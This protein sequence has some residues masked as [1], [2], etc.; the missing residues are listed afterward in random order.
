MIA[1]DKLFIIADNIDDS[2]QVQISSYEINVFRTFTEFESYI[3]LT[4]VVLD[5]LVISEHTIPFTGQNMARILMAVNSPFLKLNGNVVYLIGE[6]TDYDTVNIFLETRNIDNWAVYQGDLSVK[7]ITDIIVGN[8]RRAHENVNEI[9][10]YRIRTADYIKQQ[11]QL[12]YEDN[13]GKYKTDEDLLQGIPD[14]DEPEEITLSSEHRM[15]T[16]YIVGDS[17]M[18][19]SLMVFLLA[20]YLSMKQRVLI[21]EK[22]IDYHMLGEIVT[23]SDIPFTFIEIEDLFKN[24]TDTIDKIKL[25]NEKLVFVGTKNRLKYDYNFVFD[26][27]H[28]NLKDN[29]DFMIRE[30]DFEETPYG[31]YYTVVT[32]NNIPDL[33]KCCNSLK[34]CIDKEAATFVGVQTSD[35]GALNISSSEMKGIIEMV[36]G[37]NGVTAQVVRANGLL[38]KG[39]E[40]VYDILSIINRGNV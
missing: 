2:I 36:L 9:V 31:K 15:I 10:T 30:C 5:T 28:S 23:K 32:P 33:L 8:G 13:G 14:V 39:D 40:I 37:C 6:N 12:K 16:N 4:P 7:F 35:L 19:R 3:N 29:F 21:I 26:I 22:D 1:R 17:M 20:Q 27:L 38:L 11:N 25:A 18:E 24:V 34:Y